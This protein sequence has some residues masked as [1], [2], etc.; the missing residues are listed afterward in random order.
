M[1]KYVEAYIILYDVIKGDMNYVNNNSS[2]NNNVNKNNNCSNNNN[3][4]KTLYKFFLKNDLDFL[5]IRVK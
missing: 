5:K 4:L 3:F 1:I 2:D